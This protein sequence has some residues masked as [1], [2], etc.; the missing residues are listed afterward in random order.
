MR[1]LFLQLV[2][3]LSLHASAQGVLT[4][5]TQQCVWHPGDNF[6][7]AEPTLDETGWQPYSQWKL[8]PDQSRIWVRCHTD[9]TSLQQV[10][11]PAVQVSLWAAYQFYV[12]GSLTGSAGNIRS[13]NFSMNTVRSFS[14]S[15][16]ALHPTTIA[17]RITLHLAKKLPVSALPPLKLYAGA[18]SALRGQRAVRLLAQS[19]PDLGPAV[20]FSVAGV[21]GLIAFGLFLY[22]PARR[23]LFFLALV[24]ICSACTFINYLFVSALAAYPSIVYLAAWSVSAL[25]AVAARPVFFFALAGRR[26]TL[27]FWI[28]NAFGVLFYVATGFCAFLPPAQA[29]WIDLFSFQYL[30]L[31]NSLTQ[32]A[33]FA[34]PFFS[35]WPYS[36]IT[37]RMWPLAGLCLFWAATGVMYFAVRAA[38]LA[39]ISGIPD[40]VSK[41][42]P[43]LN[44]TRALVEVCAMVAL[45]VLLFREQRQIALERASLAGE[46]QAAS[47]IQHML[48][49]TDIESAAGLS[50][51]VAFHP[52]RE[53]G[54]DFYLCRVLSD[55]RQRILLGDVSGKG[56]A[57]A[58][59]A[60]LLLGAAATRDADPPSELLAQLNRALRESRVGGFATCLC[61]DIAVDGTVTIANAGH[62]PPYC[63]GEELKIESALPLGVAADA[64]YTETS[65]ALSPGDRLTFLSDGVVEAQS[66]AGEL[67]GFERTRAISGQAAEEIAAT[68]KRFGQQDDITVLTLGF[69]RAEVAHA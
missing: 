11:T 58:M 69:A 52:M 67:F 21:L 66:P 63:E 19:E 68:A 44:E 62:L 53:V 45:F 20:G 57:A 16:A 4:I 23:D 34:A 60:T 12:D 5:D 27:I 40:L 13:G 9:L 22:D 42:E 36:L 26:M 24:S 29:I 56:A 48:A 3:A 65:F 50:I 7:W 17:L 46:M 35:F 61:A 30:A 64:T 47:E 55:G 25:V 39:G 51:E 14:L 43:A 28:L 18:D 37:R 31:P 32:M 54:G 59:A 2:L 8:N 41:W 33:T 6:E 1:K 49:P 38:S 10:D 15:S